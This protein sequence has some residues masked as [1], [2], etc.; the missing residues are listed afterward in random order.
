MDENIA[1]NDFNNFF[2]KILDFSNTEDIK[3]YLCD[4]F[5]EYRDKESFTILHRACYLEL[6]LII[7]I[8]LE[9]LSKKK[10]ETFVKNFVNLQ[11]TMGYT[12]I[13]LAS[14]RGNIDII[15]ILIEYGASVDITNSKGLNVLHIASQGDRVDSIIY[16]KY[17]YMLNIEE[18]DKEGSS[19]LHWACYSGSD[20]V[21]NF[22]LNFN[23]NINSCDLA[24]MTPLHLAVFSGN[25]KLFRK[26][27]NS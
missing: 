18:K 23:I 17:K 10:D 15:Q 2:Q 16:F 8:L 14:Y 21:F 20:K 27:K 6:Y 5:W 11:S 19:N 3:E 9:E 13:H 25:K 24:G 4:N 22:L 12:A 7:I 1:K 26:I